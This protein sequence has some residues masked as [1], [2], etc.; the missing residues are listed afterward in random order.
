MAS[1]DVSFVVHRMT[2]MAS[3]CNLSS[4]SSLVYD[5]VVRSRPESMMLSITLIQQKHMTLF[6]T[7]L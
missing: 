5:R 1:M 3:S 7:F 6:D 4:F 2:P